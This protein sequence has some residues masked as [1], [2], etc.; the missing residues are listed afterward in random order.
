MIEVLVVDDSP[1]YRDILK[2]TIDM[3][4][5]LEVVGMAN[6]GLEALYQCEVLSPK[7]VIMDFLMDKCDGLKGTRMIK[8]RFPAI[9]VLVMTS[10]GNEQNLSK[11][12]EFGVDGYFVKGI[13]TPK[14]KQAIK[15]T[16]HG[17]PTIDQ[18]I[19]IP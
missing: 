14:L 12:L 4:K 5:E 15:N 7:L 19:F 16:I 8:R 11:A 1:E 3:D 9:K 13:E 18:D 10:I 6:D 2:T 17:I